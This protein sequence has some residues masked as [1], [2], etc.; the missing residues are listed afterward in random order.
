MAFLSRN[1]QGK[2]GGPSR[3]M[4]RVWIWGILILALTCLA[5][6]AQ[7]SREPQLKA[8]FLFNFAQFTEWPASAFAS[9]NAPFVIGVL[10]T[11]PFG[12]HLDETV[13]NESIRNRHVVVQR[14]RK[15]EEIKE[16]HILY[17][18]QSEALRLNQIIAAFK[19]KPVLTVSDIPDSAYKG[20]MIRFLTEQNRIRLRI[21]LKAAKEAGLTLSSK[22]LRLAEIVET[23]K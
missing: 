3:R 4:R 20:V 22:L 19:E 7:P 12:H 14:Y 15:L 2:S 9:T 16:C 13:R 17:I 11:D 1:G 10:G 6:R 8:V 21:N 5:S 18:S 23:T